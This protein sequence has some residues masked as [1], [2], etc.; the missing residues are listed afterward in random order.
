M[1]DVAIRVENI[2]KRYRIAAAR[3]RHDTLRDQLMDGLRSMLRPRQGRRSTREIF[4]AL[5]D[6]SFE[7]KQGE[8]VGIVG[9][10]GAGKSTLLKILSRITEPSSGRAEIYGRVGSLL[11]VGT[12]FDQELTGLENIYLSGAILGMHKSEIDRKLDEIVAFSE[13]G[14]FIDTPV[15]RYSSGMYVRLA[16]AVAAHLE[17]EI[18]IVDEVLA[19]GDAVFQRKCLGKMSDVAGEGRTVLFVSHNMAAI[20]RLCRWGIWL[21]QGQLRDFGAADEVVAKYFAAGVQSQ[22][23]LT[24]RERPTEA[25]GSEF[26][27]LLA[28]RIRSSE[29]QVTTSIDARS[30]VGVEIEYEILRPTE[31]LR[32]GFSLTAHDGTVVFSSTDT[33][34][35][36]GERSPGRHVSCGT[37]PGTFLNYGQYFLSIGSDTPMIQSHFFLDRV[38]SFT[39]EQTGG[40]GA[41]ISDGRQ[42]LLRPALPWTTRRLAS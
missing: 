40:L 7:V 9:R 8:V 27:R 28:V 26:I 37:I 3:Y 31:S 23:E 14:Q 5:R 32:V 21:D 22:G 38:L 10:N 2:S 30:S 42:G 41:H 25:P 1:G 12:G 11:E 15:K 6:V 36:D 20:T 19:V 35:Q 34:S 29:G 33:D 39:V 18:L 4:W 17:P 16:F 13:V 24:F